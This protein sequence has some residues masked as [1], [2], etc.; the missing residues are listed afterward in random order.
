MTISARTGSRW[1]LPESPRA[2]GG[3]PPICRPLPILHES[4]SGNAL[5]ESSGLPA[6]VPGLVTRHS[7]LIT[8]I[9]I[10]N[11]RLEFRVTRSKQRAGAK[12]NRE[13]MA[14][15]CLLFSLPAGSKPQASGLQN[16]IVTLELKFRAT[17]TKQTSSSIPNRYKTRLLLPGRLL[18][19]RLSHP[20]VLREGSSLRFF[21]LPHASLLPVAPPV[22]AAR[23]A[24]YNSGSQPPEVNQP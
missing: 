21:H 22:A 23:S 7:S 4:Q 2:H 9:L 6:L 5:P 24:S 3:R 15:S 1:R 19:M 10:A 16:L 8:E 18:G 14:I 20:D 17:P 11:P 12:S 13:R